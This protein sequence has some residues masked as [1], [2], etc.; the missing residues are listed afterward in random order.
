MSVTS[1]RQE[2][3]TESEFEAAL[4]DDLAAF[5][6]D[7]LGFIYY[8]FDWGIGEL[9]GMDGPDKWQKELLTSI[10]DKLKKNPEISIR[11]AIASGHGIGK[12]TMTAWL[13]MWAMSTRPHMSGVVT[14]NTMSQ[15]STKTW[16]E[17]ALWH[18][19]AINRHWF[20]WSA[21]KLW[22]KEHAATWVMNAIPNSPHNSEAFAGLHAKYKLIIFD[23]ASAIPDAI[24]T[25]TEGAMTDPRS[26]WL[27]CG[28][29]TRN[30]GR[31]KECFTSDAR[32]WT[33]RHIDSR[34]CKM[35]NKAELEEW[36]KT[37][38]ED[39]DFVKVRIK[40]E[41]PRSGMMQF[42]PSDIVE[43]AMLSDMP[44]ESWCLVPIVIG[45][46]VARYG[47]DR[48]AICLRQGRKVH[49]IRRFRELDTM[50]LA[51]EVIKAAKD[52]GGAAAIFIDGVGVGA[53]VVDRL[54]QLG[55]G[56][57]EINGGSTPIDEILFYNANAEMWHK[58]REWLKSGA[59][60]PANDNDLRLELTARTYFFDD[61]DRV[62]LE[63]KSDLKARGQESPD[64][65]DA[66]A[67]TFASDLGDLTRNSFE[68][69]E[70][71]IEPDL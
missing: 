32:R 18:K 62:R 23:E 61:K 45:V 51:G 19:R 70:S 44:F 46:D 26:I 14:A 4:T 21:T 33:T 53:G 25:V 63:R 49:E 20:S 17:L 39:S 5:Y 41:F 71:S 12:T 35:T 13:I 30:T 7:P 66:L 28:N 48:S 1:R 10:G 43:R 11:E 27:V 36:V 29:P 47:E 16:R 15:L 22:H 60:L 50:R 58:M 24:W 38:G 56:V 8:A 37:Y 40:G 54:Q 9:K 55:Y 65:A 52:Y 69:E 64:L 6:D 59:D 31:F 42:I 57:I 3:M 2:A 68:P 67:Y 34:T